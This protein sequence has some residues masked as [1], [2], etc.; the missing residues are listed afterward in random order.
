MAHATQSQ[1]ARLLDT[2][3][4]SMEELHRK[5]AGTPG[6]DTAKLEK[7]FQKYKKA[8]QTFHDD[9]LECMHTG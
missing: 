7:A 6:T 4:Q 3:A 5:L 2:H 1:A 8:H 9:A